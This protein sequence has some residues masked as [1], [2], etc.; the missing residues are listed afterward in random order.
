MSKKMQYVIGFYL[1]GCVISLFLSGIPNALY[2]LPIKLFGICFGLVIGIP[3]YSS[4]ELKL[5]FIPSLIQTA[6]YT[7]LMSIMLI[8]VYEIKEALL[9]SGIDISFFTAPL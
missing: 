7:V 3:T 2:L 1:Y 6:K 4:K 8:I 5:G 9:S